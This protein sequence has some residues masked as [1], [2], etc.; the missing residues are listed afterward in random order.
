MDSKLVHLLWIAFSCNSLP[1]V[2]GLLNTMVWMVPIKYL[3]MYWL[4]RL[5]FQRAVPR[6]VAAAGRRAQ[7]VER[8]GAWRSTTTWW[9]RSAPSTQ[10]GSSRS[11]AASAA[12]PP[13]PWRRRRRTRRARRPRTIH[14]GTVHNIL[15]GCSSVT[16]GQWVT[17]RIYLDVKAGAGAALLNWPLAYTHNTPPSDDTYKIRF[18]DYLLTVGKGTLV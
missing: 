14:S 13:R 2:S 7:T 12:A 4:R 15:Q 5:M 11:T 17:N 9:R 18:I 16:H 6:A 8:R 1:G 10:S 3:C